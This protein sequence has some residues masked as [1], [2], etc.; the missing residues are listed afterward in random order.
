MFPQLRCVLCAVTLAVLPSLSKADTIFSDFGLGNTYRCCLNWGIGLHI[1]PFH[2]VSAMAF[3]PSSDFDLSQIDLG[4]TWVGNTNSVIV[5]LQNDSSGL[6]GATIESWT[7][8]NLPPV[9]STNAIETVIPVSTVEL[10][11]TQQYWIAVA[12]VGDASA[13]WNWNVVGATGAYAQSDGGIFVL[14]HDTLGAFG[15]LGTPVPEPSSMWLLGAVFFGLV[16]FGR[17]NSNARS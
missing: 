1:P 15:V 10:M 12:G 3:T 11:A 4:I 17:R 16:A 6:P 7:V 2:T 13:V 9:G 8:S 5:S 14:N